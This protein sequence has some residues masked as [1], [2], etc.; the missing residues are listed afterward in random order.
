MKKRK[1]YHKNSSKFILE[2]LE[3]RVLFSGG[4]EGLI[5]TELEP[6]IATY[7]DIDT[8]SEQT[9]VQNKSQSSTPELQT[10]EIVFVDT[11]VEDYQTFVDDIVN[12]SESGR[13]ISVVLLDTDKNGIE[14]I[15]DTLLDYDDLDAI[16]II[17]HGEDGNIS[18]GNTS[19]N[20]NSVVSNQL[21]I[22]L[23]SDSFSE[24]GDLLIYGCNLAATTEGQSLVDTLA[25]LTQTDVAASEDLTGNVKLGGDWDLEYVSGTIEAD[26]AVSQNGQ[27]EWLGVLNVAP[28]DILTSGAL[29]LNSS[30]NG[31]S[32]TSLTLNQGAAFTVQ[33]EINP[34][35]I[36]ATNWSYGLLT[37]NVT[38]TGNGFY[39][40]VRDEKISYSQWDSGSLQG[41]VE[42]S[43][44][45]L[46]VGNWQT[47]TL[48]IDAGDPSVTDDSTA[49]IYVDAIQVGTI[50]GL[51]E[52][53]SSSQELY[54][55]DTFD[56]DVREV[57]FFDS[58][59]SSAQVAGS[60][61]T[62]YDGTEAGLVL[63]YDFEDGTGTTVT[64]R[65]LSGHDGTIGNATTNWVAINVVP[66]ASVAGAVVGFL[67]ADD[68]D[69][70]D[71]LTY[72]I[73]SDPSGNFEI[74]GREIRVSQTATLNYESAASHNITVRVTDLGGL[75]Y[76]EVVTI[77]I[78]DI[79]EVPIDLLTS[80]ALHIDNTT[81]QIDVAS[82]SLDDKTDFSVEF[83][84]N[85]AQI[86][87]SGTSFELVSQYP[88]VT[89]GY[90][91]NGFYVNVFEGK[92]S[93]SQWNN[94][95]WAGVGA[96]N[97]LSPGV[98]QTV[99]VTRDNA[100][101]TLYVDGVQVASGTVPDPMIDG[102]GTLKFL[103][104]F[105]GDV[106]EIRVFDR[107][108]TSAEVNTGLNTNLLLHYDFEEGSGTTIL[109][110]NTPTTTNNGT[111][112]NP[113]AT[114]WITIN[115]IP[116][117]SATGTVVGF[118]SAVDP[119][120]GD[121]L[122]YSIQNDPSNN[123]EIVGREIRV[124][125]GATL[126]YDSASSHVITVRVTD[127][128]TPGLTY[129]EDITIQ[130]NKA[131]TTGNAGSASPEDSSSMVINL[132]GS[133]VDGT[134]THFKLDNLPSN[135]NLYLDSGLTTLVNINQDYARSSALL[136]MYFVP[137][138]N[139]NGSTSFTYLAKDDSGQYSRSAGTA[140]F[141]VTPVN[142]APILAGGTFTL[143]TITEDEINNNGNTVAEIIAS[144]G[145]DMITD[146][147]A[148]AL[149][150]IAITSVGPTLEYSLDGG[151][152]WN[153]VGNLSF[154][155][156]LLL[157]STDK[158]RFIPDQE[159]GSTSQKFAFKAWDQ[160]S[161]IAGMIADISSNG[162]TTA[163]SE[164][165]PWA[166]I[167]ISDI[168][169]APSFNIP[170][171]GTGKLT[172]V[173]GAGTDDAESTVV[174]PDG[175]ILVAGHTL[176]G[177]NRDFALTRYNADGS[178]DTS[179]GTGG[180]VTTD[181]GSNHDYAKSIT[182]QADGR[183]L[184]TGDTYNGSNS[185]FAL[186]R[187][188]TDGSLDT[189]FDTDG[190]VTTDI[191]SGLEKGESVTVQADGRILVAGYTGGGDFAL[192]RYNT[193][194]SLDASFGSGGIVTTA[195]GS[196]TDEGYDLAVQTDGRILMTG[197]SDN[198]SNNDFALVRYNTD[199]SLDTSFG[200]NGTVTTP[201]GNNDVAT[202]V[203]IQTDGR[204]IVAGY[205]HNGT[206]SDFALV[207]YD[208][209]GNLD[210]SFGTGGI[211][212]TAVGTVTDMG[213]SVFV[214]D[215]GRIV[216]AGISSDDFAVVRYNADGSLDTDFNG[217][218]TLNA[219]PAFTEDGPAVVLDAN[220]Q[221]FD[222]ELSST[223]DFNGATLE[224]VRHGSPSGEDIYTATGTLGALV[225]GSSLVIGATTIGTVTTNSGGTL[226][227]TFNGSATHALVNAAMQQIA[228]SN[229]S[230][231]PPASVEIN[232]AFND[233]NT[234]AQGSGGT[235]QVT[236]ST[237]VTINAVNDAPA[238]DLDANDNSGAAGIN[239]NQTWTQ[240]S[241]V[242]IA[243]NNDASLLD[244]EGDNITSLTV[245]ITNLRDGADES[246]YATT[247]STNISANYTNGVL[248]LSGSDTA[249]NYQQV[250]RTVSYNNAH[251][252]PN[253]ETRVIE[254]V[255]SDGTDTSV[256][257]TTN[258]SLTTN[259]GVLVVTNASDTVDGTTTSITDLIANPGAD[260]ISLREAI[261]ASNN[262]PNTANGPDEI[263]FDIGGAGP[264]TINLSSAL[265]EITDTIKI[266]GSSGG[267][268]AI[269]L[270]GMNAG[271]VDGLKLAAGSDG[272]VIRGLVINHFGRAGVSMTSNNNTLAGNYI[273]TNI[274]G[275]AAAGNTFFGVEVTGDNN[276][277]GGENVADR[278]VI[279]GNSD[280]GITIQAAASG[281][282]VQGNYIGLES[283]GDAVLGNTSTG[284]LVYGSNTMIG[285]SSAGA[286][287]VVSGNNGDGIGIDSPGISN[288]KIQGN[289]IGTDSGGTVDLGNT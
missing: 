60:L 254:F 279:S 91:Q 268:P 144:A 16:H 103:D 52:V 153:S 251:S 263:R 257:A 266:D 191:G 15:S 184:V 175:R 20:S 97:E 61:N 38:T 211:V 201:I 83:K 243:D 253:A 176:N 140:T 227:L 236:G 45:D 250:L 81:N 92:L 76:D 13:N 267:V 84:I 24:S 225:E 102:N 65:S 174:Q 105:K 159:N 193:N 277:I 172:T 202:G 70:N 242:R 77:Q 163:F 142:D 206:D 234:G 265:P 23:W 264:H 226:L 113:A 26:I 230:D 126:D 158:V 197:Y 125:A 19:L 2:E 28:T 94:G 269:E 89:N 9:N 72:S 235:L 71:T 57:R 5:S 31:I 164:S 74:V 120:A 127:S 187:Y 181:L 198:G 155:N 258:L 262:S 36:N 56:G 54:F 210:S 30:P 10:Y 21:A 96:G 50:T 285:G 67:S 22:S 123:F 85:P 88:D 100:I 240:G 281:T 135:G 117:N 207:R 166:T 138:A 203:S 208:S 3:P 150:G 145:E 196:G 104:E 129:D 275:N 82:L 220:V 276:T 223:D 98:W 148:G 130:L 192:M 42:S 40:E 200:T 246:M 32:G 221:V 165:F 110:R 259:V 171:S 136:P 256:V 188:N 63:L 255:A 209:D 35:T 156:S 11:G 168:N 212:T 79:N 18:L 44:G 133:D 170:G 273:G 167:I 128:G 8:N 222:D 118:L 107:A 194:G 41:K 205:S 261:I 121:T 49:T 137:D 134:V 247:G 106:S 6:A 282:V 73:Q 141:N 249:A 271:T 231:I 157:R 68:P 160:T 1:N 288:N 111:I 274:T 51:P 278:N 95:S 283:N 59:L 241:A 286:R 179:F 228:Y 186:V 199:G 146:V 58:A 284:L 161:G 33:M 99:T 108:L 239:F 182:V 46:V 143:T 116:E 237:I 162:G 64:D 248:T 55:L 229:S 139:W 53:D 119:D 14:Q 204:I 260:G 244:V 131:P 151:T 114:N 189:S 272:S 17:S 233:G 173:I 124:K 47:V 270:N 87:A 48:T 216:V 213:R 185:D 183:I 169:D 62:N 90:K 218:N 43:I 177:S 232:W 75:F 34:A 238:L 12:Q 149:E 27:Q 132:N 39:L 190:I 214:Q 112:A 29:N 289:Y 80:G 178:L 115:E 101:V 86:L 215:D 152:S 109:D 280:K 252:A 66:E 154:P 37:R 25:Q 219:S 4:I 78:S 147:D 122:T 69:A 287:N 93:Y 217:T 195:V 245:T 224:L 180:T 7:L